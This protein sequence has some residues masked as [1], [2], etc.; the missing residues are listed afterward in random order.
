LGGLW[1]LE[2]SLHIAETIP[3]TLQVT[4]IEIHRVFCF[5]Q[6]CWLRPYIY[7]STNQK[8]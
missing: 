8:N 6:S 3:F 7:L 4:G 2:W 1:A 5:T